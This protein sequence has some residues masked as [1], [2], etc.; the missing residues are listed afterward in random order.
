MHS[1]DT[2]MRSLCFVFGAA[3]GAVTGLLFAQ[4]SG[5]ETRQMIR[6]STEDGRD[7]LENVAEEI[8]EKGQEVY[9]RGREMLVR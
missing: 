1:N 9:E 8:A 6:R 3:V 7:Y 2:G 5:R 4:Q